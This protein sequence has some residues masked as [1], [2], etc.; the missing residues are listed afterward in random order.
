M[1][2]QGGQGEVRRVLLARQCGAQ[3][4]PTN[5][6]GPVVGNQK[7]Q[8][9]QGQIVWIVQCHSIHRPF[10]RGAPLWILD[11]ARRTRAVL[12]LGLWESYSEGQAEWA[13]IS[14]LRH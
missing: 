14:G 11:V 12:I 5:G 4:G 8:I 10:K 1:F 9:G 3:I 2:T 7:T 13:A 6:Q